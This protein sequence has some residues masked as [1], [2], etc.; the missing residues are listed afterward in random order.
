MND[1][2][3]L[4][5]AVESAQISNELQMDHNFGLDLG[6]VTITPRGKSADLR[7]TSEDDDMDALIQRV[8]QQILDDVGN[9][10]FAAITELLEF[11]P[12]DK[13]AGFLPDY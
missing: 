11:I 8:I 12:A 5:E 3:K 1:M 10:D 4:M 6:E 13:L 2:R 7:E 9:N